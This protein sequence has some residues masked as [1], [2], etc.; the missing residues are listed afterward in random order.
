M[1]YPVELHEA[2]T[3]EFWEAIDWYDEQQDQL[4]K[5]FARELER[6]VKGISEGPQR[7]P[8][9]VDDVRKAVLRRFPYLVF[10]ELRSE[11]IFIL[12]IF[13]TSRHPKHWQA[14]H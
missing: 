9:V 4:G 7:F 6:V 13:H 2:A 14:R 10:F 11:T 3:A 8:I 5:Q 1:A 12:A